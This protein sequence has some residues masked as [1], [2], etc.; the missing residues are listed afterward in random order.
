[1][2]NRLMCHELK[3]TNQTILYA[4]DIYQERQFIFLPHIFYTDT[5]L[6]VL[7]LTMGLKTRLNWLVKLHSVSVSNSV[8]STLHLGMNPLLYVAS[9]SK[10]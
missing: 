4:F 10:C 6:T 9:Y 5:I 8:F 7:F 1:M 2:L 3:Y